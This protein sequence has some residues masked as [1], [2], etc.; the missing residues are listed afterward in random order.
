MLDNEKR[1]ELVGILEKSLNSLPH[2][3]WR[4]TL[5]PEATFDQKID[6]L[7]R[8]EFREIEKLTSLIDE[9]VKTGEWQPSLSPE[10]IYCLRN[11]LFAAWFFARHI[12]F[13][14]PDSETLI[15][16][17]PCSVGELCRWYLVDWYEGRG[18]LLLAEGQLPD[19]YDYGRN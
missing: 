7:G 6:A 2:S 8:V 17:P 13:G 9:W 4:P 14:M 1:T 10:H 3:D 18:M 15:P 5:R 12:P 11:R 16:F 19:T